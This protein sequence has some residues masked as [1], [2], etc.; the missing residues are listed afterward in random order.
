VLALLVS[1]VPE[2]GA[3]QDPVRPG[4]AAVDSLTAEVARLRATL[5]S[6]LQHLEADDP[7]VAPVEDEIA[8]LRAAAQEAADD[9]SDTPPASDETEFVGR[10]RAL[11]ALNPEL[12]VT[13]DLLASIEEGSPAENNFTARAFEFS[14]ESALDPYARAA[15]FVGY[16]GHGPELDPFG[17]EADPD[18]EEEGHGGE[19]E[20]EEGY[21]Q[22]V[23]LPGG[24]GFTLGRFRQRLGTYN[25]WHA[26]ALPGQSY[27]LPYQAFFGEEGLA[28]T[29][30]SVHWLAPFE[31]AGAYEGWVEVTQSHNEAF[32]GESR[33]LSYLGHA[34]AFWQTSP[35]TYVELSVSGLTG[36][37]ED[38]AGATLSNR[39][40]HVEAGFNWRPPE[41][42]LYREVNVRGAVM[43]NDRGPGQLSS[44]TP[45]GS[46]AIGLFGLLEI[47]LGRQWWIGGR[48]DRAENPLDPTQESWLFAP[49]VSWWQSEWVR[50]RAEYDVLDGPGGR[51]G[52]FLIQT[53]FA[54]GPHR[55][56]N[57]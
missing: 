46:S 29:G 17:S 10:Q 15:V 45:D 37:F 33:R 50:I 41:R 20:V 42:A 16:H 43:L 4:S 28:Q 34:N 55:H 38:D 22:W 12:S 24:L 23:N 7:E 1:A 40:L 27:F 8:R 5:D 18:S 57:Y 30:V 36:T 54:M 19:I 14:F 39:L 32:F 48:Y 26:H 11:Q 53:T 44:P 13:G 56:D 6:L 9:T 31:G 52:L 51:R 25:R 3:A 21:V 2:P 35:G 49:T 47:R